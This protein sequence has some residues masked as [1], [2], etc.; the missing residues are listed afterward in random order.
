MVKAVQRQLEELSY[1][2]LWLISY[3]FLLRLPSEALPLCKLRPGDSR[4][5]GEQTIIWRE[6]D[7]VCLR[8]LR[9]KNR[10]NGSGTLRRMCTCRGSVSTCIVHT[11]WDRFLAKLD[12][13]AKPWA[14]ISEG[15]AMA[16]LRKILERLSVPDAAKYG[17]HD[18][19]RGHAEDMRASGCTLAEI[20]LA[21]QWKSAAF[22]NYLDEVS[23][24]CLVTPP[25][26]A[27]AAWTG[28]A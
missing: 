5:P 6:G 21:G 17:T 13:G 22:K 19:R 3:A 9:R 26:L 4:A 14:G 11:L 27:V 16:R 12:E 20:L 25:V 28:G 1:A 8:M 7:E 18:F 15:M 24:P 23:A 2:M 10:P